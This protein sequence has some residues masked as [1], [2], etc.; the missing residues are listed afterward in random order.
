MY[1]INYGN[2]N[3]NIIQ[4]VR[5]IQLNHQHLK[6]RKQRVDYGNIRTTSKWWKNPSYQLEAQCQLGHWYEFNNLLQ[7][8]NQAIDD[9]NHCTFKSYLYLLYSSLSK[10]IAPNGFNFDNNNDDIQHEEKRKK[11]DHNIHNLSQQQILQSNIL[12]DLVRKIIDHD[13]PRIIG[14]GFNT[15]PEF[16]SSI[17][18]NLLHYCHLYVEIEEGMK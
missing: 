13:I 6:Y 7:F 1:N 12:T 10:L 3:K 9:P 16:V 18:L 11:K 17:H 8:H 4:W 15:L 2:V 5:N 14:I